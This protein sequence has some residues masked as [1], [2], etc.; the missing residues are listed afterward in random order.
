M[1]KILK[2]PKCSSEL[3]ASGGQYCCWNSSCDF[4]S[5]RPWIDPPQRRGEFEISK[6]LEKIIGECLHAASDGPFFV[7]SN[8]R[9][10]PYWEYH[11]LLGFTRE[12]VQRI[13]CQWPNVDI[14]DEHISELIGNCFANLIGY[15]H[16]CEKYW[17]DYF[18]VNL[19]QLMG[20]A[21]SWKNLDDGQS[22]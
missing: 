16:R 19:E 14:S 5:Y 6:E 12:E 22:T 9:D 8:A 4:R 18:S 2:C 20:H 11:T 3:G 15:P 21:N 1:S 10:N 13:S 17:A 7:D